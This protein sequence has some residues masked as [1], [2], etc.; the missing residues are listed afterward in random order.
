MANYILARMD[1]DKKIKP[2][3]LMAFWSRH[4]YYIDPGSA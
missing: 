2:C 3:A 1:N 4:L